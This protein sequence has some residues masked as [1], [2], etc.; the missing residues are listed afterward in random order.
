MTTD[1]TDLGAVKLQLGIA[2]TSDDAW[3]ALAITAVSRV[4]EAATFRWLAP[5]GTLTRY[6]DGTLV[7]NQGN[8]AGSVPAFY[9]PAWQPQ[10]G[11]VL[12]V[13]DGITS[14]VYLG[15]SDVDQPDDGTGSYTQITRGYHLRGAYHDGWPFTR[16]ELDTSASRLLPTAGYNAVKVTAP[17][18]PAAVLPRVGQIATNATTR[19][20]RARTSGGADL[21]IVGADGAMKLLKDIAPAEMAELV[22]VF[23]PDTRPVLASI[24]IG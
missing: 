24:G 11:R 15:V 10:Y 4:M 3:L 18:G 21:A 12:P 20:Y 8:Q 13:R 2:D 19:A 9:G 16:I 17:W 7:R 5:R 22:A 1:L 6:F 14:L 23:A